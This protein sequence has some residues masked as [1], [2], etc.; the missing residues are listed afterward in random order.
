MAAS[1]VKESDFAREG[2]LRRNK[3]A[4]GRTKDLADLERL[5]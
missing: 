4:T 2:M 1:G 5:K 3:A